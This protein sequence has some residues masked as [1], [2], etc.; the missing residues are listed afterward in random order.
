MEWPVGDHRLD[1]AP[2][3]E[4]QPAGV[5][6]G[7]HQHALTGAGRFRSETGARQVDRE[8][9]ER[10]VAPG[11][12][13]GRPLEHP[14]ARRVGQQ[15]T[16]CRHGAPIERGQDDPLAGRAVEHQL[17]GD[18]LD[19]APRIAGRLELEVDERERCRGGQGLGE[20]RNPGAAE[21]MSSSA[22]VGG[23]ELRGRQLVNSAGTLEPRTRG[24][25]EPL[26]ILVVKDDRGSVGG[27]ANVELDAVRAAPHGVMQ[28]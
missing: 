5:V 18:R 13:L 15:G 28:R 20:G 22:E 16:E 27:E 1:A 25:S 2:C 19:E 6:L 11:F 21:P 12:V 9:D 10:L 7:P 14:S 26:Q 8:A 24:R 4:R 3:P 17:S 23:E